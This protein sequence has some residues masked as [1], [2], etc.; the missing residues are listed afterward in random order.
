MIDLDAVRTRLP[1]RR[2]EWRERCETTM[3]EAASLARA[4]CPS[5]TAA[6]AEEQTGGRGRYR[7]RW[8]SAPGAGLYVSIVLRPALP[9][10][11]T[12]AVSLALGLAAAEAIARTSGAVCDLRWPNDVLIGDRKCAGVLVETEGPA[13]IAGVGVN[14]NQTEFPAELAGLATSLRLALGREQSREELLVRLLESADRFVDLLA[15][16]G[17]AAVIEAFSRASSYVSGKPV[18]VEQGEGEIVGITDG[19]DPSGFLWVR[20]P[21]GARTLILAGGVRP[22]SAVH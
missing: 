3:A 7:R 20:R 8:E 15:A 12:P 9:E 10:T 1:G 17:R 6:G 16:R 14:V 2:I 18:A 22:A 19:L 13:L 21:D 4:G 5:G 11:D